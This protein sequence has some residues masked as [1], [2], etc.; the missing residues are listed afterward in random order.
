MKYSDK[1][2]SLY[3]CTSQNQMPADMAEARVRRHI[4][5]QGPMAA[6]FQYTHSI[7]A[8]DIALKYGID[9]QVVSLKTIK[10][11]D[12]ETILECA[13]ATR[14]VITIEDGVCAGGFGERIGAFLKSK[15]IYFSKTERE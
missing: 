2:H 11:F 13:A 15:D 10:P 9:V 7:P 6:H 8:A 4:N 5:G 12:E 14:N 1:S 3:P